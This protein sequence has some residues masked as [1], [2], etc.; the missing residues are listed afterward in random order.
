MEIARKSE[1]ATG[2]LFFGKGVICASFQALGNT[3]E[4]KELLT[5][6]VMVGSRI[7]RMGMIILRLMQ[8]LPIAFDEMDRTILSTSHSAI[9][10]KVRESQDGVGSLRS[11]FRVSDLIFASSAGAVE[12]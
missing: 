2:I 10:Q 4:D 1:K 12:K 9:G 5:M 3:P 8:S 6:L 11:E 7:S